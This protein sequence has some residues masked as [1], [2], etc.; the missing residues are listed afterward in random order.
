MKT[1]ANLQMKSFRVDQF[2]QLFS[3]KGPGL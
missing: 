2:H 3:L 1:N